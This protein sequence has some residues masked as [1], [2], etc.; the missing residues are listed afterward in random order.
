ML[1]KRKI[2]PRLQHPK[3]FA[4]KACAVGDVHCDVLRVGTVEDAIGIGQ[5]LAVSVVY[6]YP[7]F[8]VEERR[9]FPG[10][11]HE[12]R[13]HVDACDSAVKARGEVAGRSAEAAPDVQDVVVWFDG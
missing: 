8:Q 6:G 3:G 5:R 9:E 1:R 4:E 2:R 11:V 10:R 12:R 13:R 7:T